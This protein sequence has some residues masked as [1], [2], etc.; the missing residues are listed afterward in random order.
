MSWIAM[1]WLKYQQWKFV[2]LLDGR[3]ISLQRGAILSEPLE[4]A[5]DP[6]G[7]DYAVLMR[8]RLPA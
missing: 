4:I 8:S 2:A 3:P 5:Q 1:D 7:C 6:A